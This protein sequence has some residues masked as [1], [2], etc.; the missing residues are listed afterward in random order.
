LQ[1]AHTLPGILIS[2]RAIGAGSGG[3]DSHALPPVYIVTFQSLF[4]S[5][6]GGKGETQSSENPRQARV[7]EKSSPETALNK[8]GGKGL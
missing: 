1:A 5:R 3:F 7:G 2:P 6:R 8:E 4:G